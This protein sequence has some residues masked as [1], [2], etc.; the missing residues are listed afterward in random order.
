MGALGLDLSDAYRSLR[1]IV[2]G[3]QFPD[4]EL[5]WDRDALDATVEVGTI[6]FRGSFETT[7]WAHELSNLRSLLHALLD[8]PGHHVVASFEFRD[9]A[10]EA[11]F[12]SRRRGGFIVEIALRPNPAH[13]ERPAFDL[14]LNSVQLTNWIEGLDTLL[15]GFPPAIHTNYIPTLEI[16]RADTPG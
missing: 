5:D 16:S 7:V 3:Q 8:Q 10:L 12:R 4:A 2:R 15:S 11:N 9:L 14:S 1:L 13:S 6:H